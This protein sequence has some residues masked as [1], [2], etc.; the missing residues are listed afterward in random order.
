MPHK[1]SAWEWLSF[2]FPLPESAKILLIIVLGEVGRWLCGGGKVRERVGD[3]IICVLIFYLVRP[4]IPK[5]PPIYGVQVRPGAVAIVITLLGGLVCM[6]VL[7]WA[8]EKKTGL[9]LEKKS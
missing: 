2:F 4:W 6:Q 3:A 9:K 8:F 5:L 7:T 1:S